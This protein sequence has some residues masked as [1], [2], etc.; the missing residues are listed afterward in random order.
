MKHITALLAALALQA[1][2]VLALAAPALA[3]QVQAGSPALPRVVS[4]AELSAM[5]AHPE[6]GLEIVDIR[7]QADFAEYSAPGAQNVDPA[8]LAADPASLSGGGPLVLV[9]KDGTT[10][11]AVGGILSQKSARPILVLKGG[12]AAWW[13]ERELGV[14]VKETPLAASPAGSP[15][16]GTPGAPSSPGTPSG[17]DAPAP[18]APPA[19]PQPP[20]SKNAGC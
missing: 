4:P 10:A 3:A 19:A 8:T 5:L 15:A 18:V 16:S 13:A 1:L 2:C 17:N 20:V 11:M 6:A 9:D 14:A 7:S 12:L